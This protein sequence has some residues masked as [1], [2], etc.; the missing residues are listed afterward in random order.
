MEHSC[1]DKGYI[2]QLQLI[3]FS[4]PGAPCKNNNV[5]VILDSCKETE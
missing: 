5:K 2:A 1:F 4:Q 3:E